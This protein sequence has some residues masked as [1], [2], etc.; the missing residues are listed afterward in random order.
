MKLLAKRFLSY[1]PESVPVGMTAHKK[2]SLEIGELIGP[3]AGPK[4]IEFAV[5]AEV[6]RL[7]SKTY[8][9]SKN[10]FVRKIKSGAAKQIAGAILER[11]KNEQKE[12]FEKEKQAAATA[13]P[14]DV[15]SVEKS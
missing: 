12:Q 3:I 2:W 1:F 6:I 8:R 7:D 10:Y 13:V 11:L 14:T 4:D 15:A 5:A 9:V